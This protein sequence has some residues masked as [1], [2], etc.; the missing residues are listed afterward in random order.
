MEIQLV[1]LL[2]L[3]LIIINGFYAA[4]EMA[5]VSLSP[6][7]VDE[8]AKS[9]KK[10]AL[11]LKKVKADSTKYLST[12]QIA[13]TLAGFLS[14]A[15]AGVKLSL[16]L[17]NLFSKM[18]IVLP[19]ML[20]II[21]I[22]LFLSFITL[23]IGE[24]VPK[25]IALLNPEKFGLFSARI[26]YATMIV[27]KPAVWLLSKSTKGVL[28]LIGIKKQTRDVNISENEI[29]R[30]IRHGH[31]KGL[32]QTEEKN[33]L[34]NIFRFDDLHAEAIMTQRTN[35]YAIDI[36]DSVESIMEQITQSQYSRILIYENSIDNILGIIHIKDVLIQANKL[37]FENLNIRKIIRKPLFVPTSIKINKLFKKM[38][39]ANYQI[40]VILDDYGGLEGIIT[41]EDLIEEI[42]GNIYDEYDLIEEEIKKLSP[43][44]YLVNG[45]MAI[46]DINRY[47]NLNISFE[48]ETLSGLIIEK[49]EYIPRTDQKDI[50]YYRNLILEVKSVVNNRIEKVLITIEKEL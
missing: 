2:I 32:Y 25:R 49:L 10:S 16:S 7:R 39:E 41:I 42:V 26:I 1:L 27:T 18:N 29:R 43:N 21:I 17:I 4:S 37:G 13:I 38:Q 28:A 9:N 19:E 33:M 30:L 34:E 20:A 48:Y 24:L 12:I 36:D 44:Q 23:V 3:I 47:L 8:L 11:L 6:S 5:L 15:L 46:Q 45:T 40:A 14:S 50:V 35:V 22:T 31:S